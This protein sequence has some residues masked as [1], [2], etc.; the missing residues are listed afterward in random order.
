MLNLIEQRVLPPGGGPSHPS[1]EQ[2]DRYVAEIASTPAGMLEFV[3]VSD[4]THMHLD[5]TDPQHICAVYRMALMRPWNVKL[6]RKSFS[7]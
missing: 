5:A 3:P 2:R 1:R 6:D 4:A 7:P